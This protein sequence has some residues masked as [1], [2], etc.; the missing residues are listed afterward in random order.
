MMHQSLLRY[1]GARVLLVG[2]DA[3]C[4]GIAS[5]CHA[6]RGGAARRRHVAGLHPGHRGRS[7]GGLANAAGNTQASLRSTL[8]SVPGWTSAHVMLGLSLAVVVTLH[9][10][11]QFGWNVHTLAYVFMMLVIASGVLGLV[12]YMSA[13]RQLSDNAAGQSRP[14]NVR[15]AAGDRWRGARPGAQV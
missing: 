6:S 13:P 3:D 12:L 2:A 1:R 14:G 4:S 15:R 7:I 10:G 11:F 5:L 8:G 9:T